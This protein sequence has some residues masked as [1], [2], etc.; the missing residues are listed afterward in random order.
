MPD[1]IKKIDQSFNYNNVFFRMLNIS[2]AKT[3]NNR[4]RWIN[5]FSDEK[6]CVTV[7]M[8]LSMAG[9]ERFLLDAFVDDVTGNR[10]E[11]NTDQIPRG[12]ITL[13]SISTASSEFANPNIYVP[14]N[15]KIHDLYTKVITKIYAIPIL[16]RYNIEIR[17]DSEIDVYKLLEKIMDL[18]FNYRFFNMDYFGIKI[19][20]VLELPDDKQIKLP[21][22]GDISLDSDNVKSVT[23]SLDVRTN[24]PSWQVDTDEVECENI[25]FENIKRVYWENYIYDASIYKDLTSGGPPETKENFGKYGDFKDDNPDYEF[26]RSP[27]TGVTWG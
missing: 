3:L 15:T 18:L 13:E 10:V 2:L 7:P 16:A 19:D 8:Y 11:L 20:N 23:F 4:L 22:D 21:R 9:S 1:S 5:Y 26:N 25:E 14:K 12:I 17:V 27:Q 24:Y 6:K